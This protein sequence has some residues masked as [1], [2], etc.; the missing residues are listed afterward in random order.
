MLK[1]KLKISELDSGFNDKLFEIS[2]I[3]LVDRGTSFKEETISLNLTLLKKKN[4][5]VLKG[6]LYTV[7][8]YTCVRC[9]NTNSIQLELPINII[10]SKSINKKNIINHMNI[11]Y[12]NDK[13]TY[14]ECNEI[15][16]DLIA[17]AEPMNPLCKPDCSGLCSICG[18]DKNLPCSCKNETNTINQWEK[19][20]KLQF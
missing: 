17:L 13:D 20:K 1:M 3:N 19:L 8:E 7:P 15:F 5:F 14:I 10:I 16:A 18:I 12:Y 2:T 9:L 4:Y 11:I 6:V